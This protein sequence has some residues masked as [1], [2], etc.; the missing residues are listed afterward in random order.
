MAKDRRQIDI[1]NRMLAIGNNGTLIL[2]TKGLT[3]GWLG[4]PLPPIPHL[5]GRG[6]PSE[7]NITIAA[8]ATNVSNI[9]FQIADNGDAT[10][11]TPMIF[12]I[13]L[14]DA[15]TG[16]GL[17]A[18]AF[19]GGIAAIASDGI[20]WSVQTAAKA[21]RVQANA[22]GLFG[23]AI[24]DTAKSLVWPVAQLPNGIITVGAKLVT[25]NYG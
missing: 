7:V 1:H 11:A 18:A 25:A 17:T 10:V 13:W 2:D 8:G 22:A 3:T 9:F 6:I 4:T 5:T 23:L 24:T 19:S 12:D 16:A 14:S 15:A 21:L 20:V